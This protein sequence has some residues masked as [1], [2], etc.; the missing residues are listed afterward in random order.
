MATDLEKA[1]NAFI[2]KRAKYTNRWRYYD[3]DQPLIYSTERLAEIFNN[4]NARF[5][6]NWC[7]VV[8]DS[9]LDRLSLSGFDVAKNKTAT[10]TLA[11]LWSSQHIDLDAD[12]VHTACQVTG[13]AFIIVEKTK[14]G[15]EEYYNDPRL[16]HM[17]YQANSPKKKSFAAKWYLGDDEKNYMVLYYP[18]R[19]ETYVAGKE[20]S[21]AKAFSLA[22]TKGKQENEFGK[23]PVFHFRNE[24]RFVKSAIENALTIQDA[25]NKLFSDMM[26]AAEFGAFKQRWIISNTDTSS[27]P[28]VPGSLWELPA[29]DGQGQQTAVGEFGESNLDTFLNSMNKLARSLSIITRTP[30]SFLFETGAGISG[31]ALVA[32]EAPLNKKVESFQKSYQVTWIELASFMLEIQ[33]QAV[34]ESDIAAVWERTESIQPL[35]QAQTRKANVEAG[36]PLISQLREEGKNEKEIKEIIAEINAKKKRETS[37]AKEL[38]EKKRLESEQSNDGDAEDAEDTE[39]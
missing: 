27:L 25:I 37:L 19:I 18:D 23:I 1:Y 5:N 35:S 14:D 29:S 13:E 4:V 6:E 11:D 34:K 7:A 39:A 8:V 22:G 3:G 28:N 36:M 38:L 31:D 17:F 33:G 15:V 21:S 10:D 9:V 12:D 30:K 20:A 16:V 24:R 26:V 32:M 2:A